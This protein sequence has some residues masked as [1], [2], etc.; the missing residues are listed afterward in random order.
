MRL[1]APNTL[2]GWYLKS[3]TIGGVDV[4]DTLYDFGGAEATVADAQVVLSSAGA[5]IAGSIETRPGARAAAA[6]VVAFSTSRDNW[7]DGSRHVKRVPSG[8]NGSFDVTGLPPG[9]YYVA[10]VDADSP[11]D[12]QA[13]ETL[14]SLVSRA[15]RVTA[16][17]GAV[18]TVAL[19]LIR[20]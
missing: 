16:R 1:T 7:F 12:L 19:T 13:P 20:R 5:G 15:V 6:T 3:V 2:P 18:S 9:E 4:T 14:E 8:P 11:L 10:A 17:E